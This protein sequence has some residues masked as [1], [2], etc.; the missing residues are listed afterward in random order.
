MLKRGKLVTFIKVK[1]VII[2][3]GRHR[4]KHRQRHRH[5]SRK[6]PDVFR[7]KETLK[8]G[9]MVAAVFAAAGGSYSYFT[10]KK[11]LE[12]EIR[13]NQ[14]CMENSKALVAEARNDMRMNAVKDA[15]IVGAFGTAVFTLVVIYQKIKQK[16]RQLKTRRKQQKI[17]EELEEKRIKNAKN[18]ARPV[19]NRQEPEKESAV[20][21]QVPRKKTR[22]RRKRN[23]AEIAAGILSNHFSEEELRVI[24]KWFSGLPRSVTDNIKRGNKGL[25]TLK[26]LFKNRVIQLRSLGVSQ[27]SLDNFLK[28]GKKKSSGNLDA[29]Y[30]HEKNGKP[31]FEIS[32]PK[33]RKAV[34]RLRHAKENRVRSLRINQL[35][36][37]LVEAG[38]TTEEGGS[39]LKL[40]YN[41]EPVK[42]DDNRDVI[43][44]RGTGDT[45]Y[46]TAAHVLKGAIDFL[47]EKATAGSH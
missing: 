22:K 24:L 36:K 31:D 46:G 32:D 15:A 40:I 6:R 19:E 1:C 5:N 28:N 35:Q 27:E 39:H 37:L 21:T 29:V 12:Q 4:K 13:S 43:V 16:I 17:L 14:A 18:N 30:V 34:G 2:H 41:G 3:M 9:L 7:N 10:S 33:I 26:P 23:T 11:Q 42:Y 8:S 47:L 20:V 45:K 44:Q 25:A 38:F